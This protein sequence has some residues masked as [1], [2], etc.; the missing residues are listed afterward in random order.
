MIQAKPQTITTLGCYP[1]TASVPFDHFSR[2]FPI[3]LKP[4]GKL[5]N[6]KSMNQ[7]LMS[8]ST[9]HTRN[10]TLLGV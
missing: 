1:S 8:D 4:F 7:R 10:S 2:T 6:G 9:S 3:K 5:N